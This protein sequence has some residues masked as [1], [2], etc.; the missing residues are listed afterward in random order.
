M[1]GP[2]PYGLD[3]ILIMILII[4]K[5][6]KNVKKFLVGLGEGLGEALEGAAFRLRYNCGLRLMSLSAAR[7]GN[8]S[9]VVGLG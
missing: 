3:D 4:S 9:I 1:R 7:R 5:Y 8:F 6:A 2:S